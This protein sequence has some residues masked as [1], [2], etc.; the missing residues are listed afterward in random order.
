MSEHDAAG[1]RAGQSPHTSSVWLP[2]GTQRTVL[3]DASP[4]PFPSY[5]GTPAV[6]EVCFDPAGDV[7]ARMDGEILGAFDAEASTS[8][9]NGGGDGN[10]APQPRP[11]F[12][13][14]W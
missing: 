13:L 10:D 11:I 7:V 5:D 2:A 14:Q 3:I 6:V 8:P 9:E 4:A 1:S 12:E